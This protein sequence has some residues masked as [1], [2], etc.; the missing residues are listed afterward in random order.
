MFEFRSALFAGDPLLQAIAD[1]APAPG[2]RLTRISRTQNKKHPAVRK[3]QQALLTWDPASLPAFGADGSFGRESARAVHRF[4]LEVLLVAEAEIVDDVGPLT[5]Q[6]LDAIR[7][8]AES[9]P[10][11]PA[12]ALLDAV[13]AACARLEPAG[14]GALLLAHGLDI[15]A[16]DLASELLRPLAVDR[17]LPGFGDLAGE[18]VRG[19]EPGRPAHSL[20]YHAFASP[21]VLLDPSG[22]ALGDFPT[23]DELDAVENLVFGMFP[24]SLPELLT[25]FPGAIMA[26]AV[27]AT[28]YRP[29]PETVHRR[30]AELCL[31]RTGVARVG[32]AEPL[33]DG[34][35]RGF[36]PFDDA[37]PHAFRVL[38]ARYAPYLAVQLRGRRELF[39]PMNFNLGQ[40][41]DPGSAGDETH[42]FWVPIHKLFPGDECLRETSL[43]VGLEAR[44]VNEKLRRVHRELGRLGHDT[45]WTAPDINGP[46]FIFT[47]RIAELEPGL[48]PGVL[49]PVPQ[50]L[51]EE[52]ALDGAT[53]TFIV[54]PSTTD[55]FLPSLTI[56]SV[57]ATPNADDTPFRHAPEYVHVR[58]VEG[59]DGREDLNDDPDAVARV[60]AGGYRAVHYVDFSGDGS[61]VAICPE[62]AV[63]VPRNVPAY[64]VVTAP[65]FYPNCDQREL[66]EWWLQRVPSALRDRVWHRV[67]PLTLSD[68][69]IAPNIELQ[70]VDFRAE[71]TT[72]TAIVS[73]PLDTDPAQQALDVGS[74]LRHAHLPDGAAGIFAPGWDTSRD[75]TDGVVHLAGYGLGS[76][77]PEDAKLC[78]ALS[79]FWPAVAPDSGRSFS[80]PAPTP[81]L[82]APYPTATPLTDEEIGIVGSL[83]W[84]GIPGPVMVGAARVEYANFDFVDYVQ[85]ALDSR[86][87]L[88][89]TGRVDVV[90]YEAR[91]LAAVRAYKAL[92][93]A[94]PRSERRWTVLSFLT[95][96]PSDAE[97][98][99]AQAEAGLVLAG[100]F[101]RLGFGRRGTPQVQPDHR[102]VQ[103][104][105]TET[106]TLFAGAG[107]RLL[108]KR[109][110]AAWQRVETQ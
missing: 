88:A 32:T 18:G 26:V 41:F 95:V 8:D 85:T 79:T 23:L 45:G 80:A 16:P 6:E 72:V 19:I 14:W 94:S 71:D 30:H 55:A 93:V 38:P 47:D 63:Q 81:F 91:V 52:A 82:S 70:G 27:F 59:P 89:L 100:P 29:G 96:D 90:E 48:G 109:G 24:P 56:A 97:L 53:V 57:G 86:F 103:V 78:A 51:V 61:I 50:P 13:A 106:A 84:D 35:A 74:T 3:V 25:R 1:D 98:A 67:A 33:Y 105:L 87:T 36:L 76:P 5:V 104:D 102:R 4:K 58:H 49:C 43:T 17:S 54:P 101:F 2:G 22:S 37:D 34:A 83:P 69:R 10:P 68:E 9:P 11:P 110:S 65:D 66:L 60:R 108:V 107:S 99:A 31:S 40:T 73:L 92:G 42:D 21:N 7:A 44:H 39:G 46:P 20:L 12:S 75:L 77:F 62:L 28:E 64:S 15:T